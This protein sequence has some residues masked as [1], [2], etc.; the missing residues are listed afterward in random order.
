MLNVELPSGLENLELPSGLTTLLSMSDESMVEA[1]NSTAIS[2]VSHSD[3]SSYF[4]GLELEEVEV[5]MVG[6]VC[7]CGKLFSRYVC[8]M[9]P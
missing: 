7:D 3:P 4:E 6:L 9:S 2:G 5:T 1:R 8:L